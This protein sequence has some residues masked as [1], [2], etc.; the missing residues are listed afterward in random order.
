MKKR[1]TGFYVETLILIGV[2]ICIILLITQAFGAAKVRSTEAKL[3]TNSVILAENAAEAMSSCSGAEE[4]YRLLDKGNAR[5]DPAGS[6]V[7]A[8][9]DRDMNPDPEGTLRLT[10]QWTGAG[11]ASDDDAPETSGQETGAARGHIIVTDISAG[12]EVFSMDTAVCLQPAS[13]SGS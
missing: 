6:T 7:A 2:F 8:Y 9:Y 12:R 13:G 11:A 10:L 5:F 3:L 4:L 1:I